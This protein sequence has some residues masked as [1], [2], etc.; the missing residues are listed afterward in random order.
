MLHLPFI[1]TCTPPSLCRNFNHS[2][3]IYVHDFST[4]L[5][6]F[7]SVFSVFILTP[8]D[9]VRVHRYFFESLLRRLYICVIHLFGSGIHIENYNIW[10]YVL[11]FVFVFVFVDPHRIAWEKLEFIKCILYRHISFHVKRAYDLGLAVITS[12]H[13]F[14]VW[15]THTRTHARKHLLRSISFSFYSI[16]TSLE[17]ENACK[18]NSKRLPFDKDL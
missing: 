13:H 10:Y 18:S 2:I 1:V 16:R 6:V 8:M 4:A 11:R 3:H 9:T 17:H 14:T 7:V 5:S 12:I 15:R